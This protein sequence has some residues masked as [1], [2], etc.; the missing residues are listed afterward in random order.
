MF[1]WGGWVFLHRGDHVSRLTVLL[2]AFLD[3]GWPLALGCKEGLDFSSISC[4]FRAWPGWSCHFLTALLGIIDTIFHINGTR[5]GIQR[6]ILIFQVLLRCH[7]VDELASLLGCGVHFQKTTPF[8]AWI[9]LLLLFF[10]TA[11]KLLLLL[12]LVGD[13]NFEGLRW[14]AFLWLLSETVE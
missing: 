11:M 3:V 1:H 8:R 13:L 9:R 7:L 2:F 12:V 6:W 5:I 4:Q 14:W 10:A